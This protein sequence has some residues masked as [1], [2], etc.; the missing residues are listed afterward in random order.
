MDGPKKAPVTAKTT[1][2]KDEFEGEPL[3]FIHNPDGKPQVLHDDPY[4]EEFRNDL[5]L[6]QNEFKKWLDIFQAAEG[7]IENVARSYKKFGLKLQK[8]NDLTFMEWA[9]GAKYMCIFG[10]FNNWKRGEYV[11][12]KNDFGSFE[13]LLKANPDGSPKIPHRT[14]YKI[15]I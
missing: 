2:K 14:K 15:Q 5:H 6:R 12:T 8:N 1:S 7:G 11:C 4:L 3:G 13:C 10:E 9:P